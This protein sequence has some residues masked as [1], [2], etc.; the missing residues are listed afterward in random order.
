MI[1]FKNNR[2]RA[3]VIVCDIFLKKFEEGITYIQVLDT[4]KALAFMGAN[5]FG[6]RLKN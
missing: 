4:N 3:V 2:I 1:I 6:T 5:Y